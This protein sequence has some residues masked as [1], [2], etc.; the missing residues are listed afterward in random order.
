MHIPVVSP[1]EISK[2]NPDFIFILA[3]NFAKPIM[4]KLDQFK[5]DGGRFIVP[6][7]APKIY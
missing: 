5:K 2:T 1:K 4:K 6:V 7:P 3:W